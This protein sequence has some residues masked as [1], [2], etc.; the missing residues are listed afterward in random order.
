MQ[1]QESYHKMNPIQAFYDLFYNICYSQEWL[2]I[3]QYHVFTF[4]KV[5]Q[6]NL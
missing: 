5:K 1:L 3:L 2:Y 6:Q 4:T